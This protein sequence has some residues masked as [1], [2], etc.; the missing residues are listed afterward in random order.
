MEN[1]LYPPELE[2]LVDIFLTAPAATSPALRRAIEAYAADQAGGQREQIEA[3]PEAIETWVKKVTL[4]AYKTM[5]EEVEAMIAAGYSEDEIFEVTL[6]ATL[7]AS[8]AR[9]EQGLALL[10]GGD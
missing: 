9:L 5:D 6:A 8:L 7:G 4:S 2:K 10:E 1:K 3:L